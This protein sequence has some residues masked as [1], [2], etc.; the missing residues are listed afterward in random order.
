MKYLAA[1]LIPLL[2]CTPTYADF[3]DDAFSAIRTLQEKWYSFDTGLW[4]VT[5]HFS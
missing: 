3:A 2:Y 1:L 5:I 4:Y